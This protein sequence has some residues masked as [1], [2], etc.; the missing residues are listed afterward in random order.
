LQS[1]R[2]SNCRPFEIGMLNHASIFEPDRHV[3]QHH[4]EGFGRRSQLQ[5]SAAG[6]QRLCPSPGLLAYALRR[7]EPGSLRRAVLERLYRN[8][9]PAEQRV[10]DAETHR[11]AQV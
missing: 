5:K 8:L 4:Q 2:F 9:P 3:S 6:R 1:L 11:T 7:E 10:C